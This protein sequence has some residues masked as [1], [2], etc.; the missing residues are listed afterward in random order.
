MLAVTGLHHDPDNTASSCTCLSA[1][2]EP[3]RPTGEI[4]ACP[5]CPPAGSLGRGVYNATHIS[6]NCFADRNSS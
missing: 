5:W 3:C 2:N 1:A 4:P 6:T